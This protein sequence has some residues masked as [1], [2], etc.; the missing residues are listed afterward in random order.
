MKRYGIAKGGTEMDFLPSIFAT[1]QLRGQKA[2]CPS[3]HLS[4]KKPAAFV[5]KAVG[6]RTFLLDF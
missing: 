2:L 5:R 4:F 3:I 6:F 1:R